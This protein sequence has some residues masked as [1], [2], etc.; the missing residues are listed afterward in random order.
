MIKKLCYSPVSHKY[1]NDSHIYFQ[2]QQLK[3]FSILSMFVLN[4]NRF[5]KM[6]VNIPQIHA[7]REFPDELPTKYCFSIY[8]FPVNEAPKPD[9]PGSLLLPVRA[10]IL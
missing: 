6:S 3:S 5:C 10:F 4:P 9:L 7:G 2:K 1:F 8:Y